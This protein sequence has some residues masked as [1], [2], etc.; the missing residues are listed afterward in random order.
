[1]FPSYDTYEAFDKHNWRRFP[2][3]LLIYE[4]SIYNPAAELA[5]PRP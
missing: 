3:E 1:M 5:T 2:K 4:L